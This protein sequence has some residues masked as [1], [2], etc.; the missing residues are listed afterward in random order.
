MC[1][2]RRYCR[3]CCEMKIASGKY[4]RSFR[5]KI[6]MQ[7]T[8]IGRDCDSCRLVYV[9]T[10]AGFCIRF[11]IIIYSVSTA[12]ESTTYICFF[13]FVFCRPFW[14]NPPR[15]NNCMKLSLALHPTDDYVFSTCMRT[16]NVVNVSA[17]PQITAQCFVLPFVSFHQLTDCLRTIGH[18][19][20]QRDTNYKY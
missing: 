6:V 4:R 14:S 7:L 18:D 20:P 9:I 8:T 3:C 12:H 1:Q 17:S 2:R 13:V 19:E 15:D 10:W 11:Q 16:C 5:P